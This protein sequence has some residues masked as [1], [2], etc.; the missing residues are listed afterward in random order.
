[1]GLGRAG[2]QLARGRFAQAVEAFV[3]GAARSDEHDGDAHALGA[4][5]PKVIE[6]MNRELVA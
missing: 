1:M 5:L 6:E 3:E 2:D 4:E